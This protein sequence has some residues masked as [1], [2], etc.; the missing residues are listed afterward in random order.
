MNPDVRRRF[1]IADGLI[2]IAGLAAGL[3]LVRTVAPGVSPDQIRD[4][5]ARPNQEW[6][7][8]GVFATS[9]ELSSILAVPFLAG[10]TPACLLIQCTAPRPA[11]RR[12][13]RQTGF[14]ACLIPT[15]VVSITVATVSV[16]VRLTIWKAENSSIPYFKSHLLGG[17]LAGSGV[18]WSWVTMG[19]CGVGRPRPTWTD[20]LGRLTGAAWVAVGALSAAYL[21]LVT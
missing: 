11:W 20:R 4:A 16:C 12:L 6:S 18:L 14:V 1:G 19:L 3:G 17:L 7:A 8:W 5:F 21:F 10:W 9:L 13:I 2:L 15:G